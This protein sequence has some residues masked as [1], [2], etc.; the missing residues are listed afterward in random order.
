MNINPNNNHINIQQNQRNV[1][2]VQNNNP[3]QQEVNNNAQQEWLGRVGIFNQEELELNDNINNDWMRQAGVFNQE[4]LDLNDD[5]NNDWMRQA[6]VFDQEGLELNDDM[7][8]DW[9]RQAGVFNREELGLPVLAP[10]INIGEYQVLQ[11]QY[12]EQEFQRNLDNPKCYHQNI[13]VDLYGAECVDVAIL[14]NKIIAV[15]NLP[16][17]YTDFA[18]LCSLNREQMDLDKYK[19]D[20][21]RPVNLRTPPSPWDDADE[22]EPTEPG[23]QIIEDDRIHGTIGTFIAMGPSEDYPGLDTHIPWKIHIRIGNTREDWNKMTSALVP[24]LA[25]RQDTFFKVAKDFAHLP[26]GNQQG[27]G[28]TIY[29]QNKEHFETISRDLA[30]IIENNGLATQE[31]GIAGDRALGD[32]GR[33]FYRYESN[34]SNLYKYDPETGDEKMVMLSS[35]DKK[36]Y[37]ANRGDDSYMAEGMTEADDPFYNFDPLAR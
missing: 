15:N 3:A 36:I 11:E 23:A 8:Y 27:K 16:H 28:I 9:M 37:A 5:I 21:N 24:Y 6:G 33:L 13:S 2:K 7:D 30:Q 1:Q 12:D 34:L 32:N 20:P 26:T 18:P 31:G 14:G 29:P 25:D 17:I 35:T 22:V 4:E 19:A 10:G